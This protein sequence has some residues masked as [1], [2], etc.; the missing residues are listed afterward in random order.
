MSST[1]IWLEVSHYL[2]KTSSIPKEKLCDTL[3][4]LVNLSSMHIIDFEMELYFG[5][6][7]VLGEFRNYH[8]IGFSLGRRDASI[9]AMMKK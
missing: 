8:K 6:I 9:I 5:T 3:T 7:K 4:K 2:Y 1:I